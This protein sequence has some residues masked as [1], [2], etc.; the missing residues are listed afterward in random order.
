MT[1]LFKV[2][3]VTTSFFDLFKVRKLTTNFLNLFKVSK[4]S[5]RS[6]HL[7]AAIYAFALFKHNITNKE[8][9]PLL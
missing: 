3:K 9:L 6:S 8:Y 4:E 5:P 1:Y 7:E 2:N